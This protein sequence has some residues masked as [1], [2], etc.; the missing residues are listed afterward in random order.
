MTSRASVIEPVHARCETTP[1]ARPYPPSMS[2]GVSCHPT[3]D[4]TG[5]SPRPN[6]LRR[7]SHD[8]PPPP[9]VAGARTIC[10][11]WSRNRKFVDSPLE[12]DGVEL[13]V[14]QH[15]SPGFPK[16]PGAELRANEAPEPQ[17][18]YLSP[19]KSAG[20]YLARYGR[21]TRCQSRPL[22]ARRDASK[23]NTAPTSPG[24]QPRHQP[25]EAGA[26]H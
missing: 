17:R 9:L 16:H 19:A 3:Y 4:N 22:R 6:E 24:A 2:A 25:L 13:I 8:C 15:E 23:H 10:W 21:R 1:H 11:F 20:R 14:R 26:F 5:N 18:I 7:V 12:G